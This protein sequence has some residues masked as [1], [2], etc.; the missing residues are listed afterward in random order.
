MPLPDFSHSEPDGPY[1]W[2][3]MTAALAMM[4]I[5]GFGMFACVVALLPVATEFGLTRAEAS[6]P[7]TLFTIGFGAGGIAYGWAV[8]RYGAA[9]IT[10][11]AGL[12]YGGGFLLASSAQSFWVYAFA[13]GVPIGL[14]G[15]SATF[16]PLV[17]DIS[18]WF[19]KR[20]GF[21]IGIVISGNYIAGAIWPPIV[22]ALIDGVGWRNAL[23]LVGCFCLATMPPLALMLRRRP[24]ALIE[25]AADSVGAAPA[26]PLGLDKNALQGV[27]CCAGIACCIAMSMP[28]V[29]IVAFCADL[30]LG[31]VHGANMLA[32][33]M[34]AGVASR[35]ISGWISDKIGGYRTL[36]L[37]SFLQMATLFLFL[38]FDT[39]TPLYVVSFL[40]GLS[41]GGIVPSYAMIVRGAF[42]AKDAGWRIGMVMS[43]TLF[44][45]AIGGWM[46]GYAY[47]LTGSYDAA[48]FNGI[49]WNVLNLVIAPW[50]LFRARR[51]FRAMGTPAVP[52]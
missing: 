18:F 5:G 20:R 22:Q 38:P 43:F 4:T 42:P 16:S 45:M 27:L 17:A 34:G 46:S 50:L 28:Q 49:G 3:R 19:E 29:H 32:I 44:G 6:L 40:F 47:D 48:V 30:G 2:A 25:E 9:T 15:A 7:Y 24:K 8:T 11:I 51:A 37:G 14:L 36:V 31:A 23:A 33:M 41:Q 21:A 39:L 12:I 10:F 26:R 35:L 13:F 1:A 52:A